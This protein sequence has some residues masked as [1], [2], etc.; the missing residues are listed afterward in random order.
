LGVAPVIEFRYRTFEEVII[1]DANETARTVFGAEN[2][3][4]GQ[5]VDS[6]RKFLTDRCDPSQAA[7]RSEEQ[8][9]IL[10][11]LLAHAVRG[12]TAA[13][14]WK[15]PSARIPI[16]LNSSE[17][18]PATGKPVGYLPIILRYHFDQQFTRVRYLYLRVSAVMKKDSTAS[19]YVCDI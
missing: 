19:Y 12:R 6:L 8:M 14:D 2:V 17:I 13:K 5:T 7:A 11:A 1:T 15:P 16:V 18:D 3:R 9:A 10:D 4:K